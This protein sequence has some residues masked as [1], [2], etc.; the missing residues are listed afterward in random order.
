MTV[1]KKKFQ[2]ALTIAMAGVEDKDMSPANTFSFKNGYVSAFRDL[3]AVS[4][5]I[6]DALKDLG[7][8]VK[9]SEFFKLINKMDGNELTIER[10]PDSIIVKAGKS[11][12]EFGGVVDL[13]A[14]LDLVDIAKLERL[15][16]DKN[17]FPALA[18]CK[19]GCEDGFK[20][21]GVYFADKNAVSTDGRRINQVMLDNPV[22]TFK[23]EDKAAIQLAKMTDAESFAVTDSRVYLFMPNGSI[24]SCRQV[25]RAEYPYQALL[26]ILTKFAHKEGDFQSEL[27]EAFKAMIDR[28]EVMSSGFDN[29]KN[30][31]TIKFSATGMEVVSKKDSGKYKEQMDWIK[32]KELKIEGSI[33]VALDISLLFYALSRSKQFYVSEV[34]DQQRVVF[35]GDKCCCLL[36]TVSNN[37]KA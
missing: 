29:V 37:K 16:I 1:N 23:I 27:P 30:M 5:F 17:F 36:A 10:G 7:G 20:Y 19:L 11:E 9:A 34:G 8:T 28:A 35:T 14:G 32:G 25:Q 13:G 24:A 33:E 31:V 3:I 2:D 15:P 22:P 26:D 12:A 6:D 4:V 18:Y 21:N